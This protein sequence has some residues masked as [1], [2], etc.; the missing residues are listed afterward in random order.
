MMIEII[1]IINEVTQGNT[2]HPG[3]IIGIIM[4]KLKG[5]ADGSR[6]A[7]LVKERMTK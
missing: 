4:S 1:K 3:K 7:E 6:V 2:D 5:R